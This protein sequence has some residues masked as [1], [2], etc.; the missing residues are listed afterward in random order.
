M[1]DH[2]LLEMLKLA[3]DQLC[4]LKG[5]NELGATVDDSAGEGN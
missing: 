3:L 2:D 4:G 1:V 5:I